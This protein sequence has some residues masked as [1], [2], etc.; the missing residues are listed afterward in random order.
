[1]SENMTTEDLFGEG[2]QPDIPTSAPQPAEPES[3]ATWVPR[4]EESSEDLLELIRTLQRELLLTRDDALG[5]R[6]ELA[7][8]RQRWEEVADGDLAQALLRIDQLEDQ[9]EALRHEILS[10]AYMHEKITKQ[11]IDDLNQHYTAQLD[12]LRGSRTWRVGTLALKPMRV[13]RRGARQ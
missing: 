3:L 4:G 7:V 2:A 6:A 11:I 13:L 1:M 9:K 12:A 5:T 8:L 10:A